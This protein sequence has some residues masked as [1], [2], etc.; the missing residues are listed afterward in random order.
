MAHDLSKNFKEQRAEIRIPNA[1]TRTK[2]ELPN[3]KN[4]TTCE[5]VVVSAWYSVVENGT[6]CEIVP[7]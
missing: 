7:F 6:M 5:R 3:P 1:E 4:G 2:P